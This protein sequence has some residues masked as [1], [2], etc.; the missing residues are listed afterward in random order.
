MITLVMKPTSQGDILES[1]LRDG[2][3]PS[4]RLWTARTFKQGN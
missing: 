3:I 4:E 2:M 1:E